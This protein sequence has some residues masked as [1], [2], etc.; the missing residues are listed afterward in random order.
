M[1]SRIVEPTELLDEELDTLEDEHA[2][3]AP[4]TE[5]KIVR[6]LNMRDEDGEPVVTLSNIAKRFQVSRRLVSEISSRHDLTRTSDGKPLHPRYGG[7]SSR[8]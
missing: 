4:E 7:I 5:E 6:L 3:E 8:R 1:T 2:I